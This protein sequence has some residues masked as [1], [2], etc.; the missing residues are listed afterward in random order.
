MGGPGS[1]KHTYFYGEYPNEN[2]NGIS[3]AKKTRLNSLFNV[4]NSMDHMTRPKVIER[5]TKLTTGDLLGSYDSD[6][7]IDCV[8][9]KTLWNLPDDFNYNYGG[10]PDFRNTQQFP[11]GN[12]KYH[13]N[14][15]SPGPHSGI[16]LGSTATDDI[17][18]NIPEIATDGNGGLSSGEGKR[19][20][21]AQK[22]PGLW[23]GRVARSVEVGKNYPVDTNGNLELFDWQ[24]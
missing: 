9:A 5:W 17:K 18:V 2:S 12:I 8:G 13:P 3:N 21:P 22:S 10:A 24:T 1:N 7:S 15:G 16:D 4:N 11:E 14:L 20:S 19:E 23:S 6:I